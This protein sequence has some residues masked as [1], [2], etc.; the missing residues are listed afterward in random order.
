MSRIH[1]SIEKKKGLLDLLRSEAEISL[2]TVRSKVEISLL[3][4]KFTITY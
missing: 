1:S 3:T 4:I 2:L